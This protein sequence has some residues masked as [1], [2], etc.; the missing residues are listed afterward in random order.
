MATKLV[1][2]QG[3]SYSLTGVTEVSPNSAVISPASIDLFIEG[4]GAHAGT[5]TLTFAPSTLQAPAFTA[6][7][8]NTAPAVFTIDPTS[9]KS[10]NGSQ[11]LVLEDDESGSVTVIGVATSPGGPVPATA[12][13]TCKVSS[14]GQ[15]SVYAS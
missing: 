2:V 15:T 1:A 3:F 11:N 8:T 14:A 5:I 4:N 13:A 10:F 12:S 9:S 6:S 7:A